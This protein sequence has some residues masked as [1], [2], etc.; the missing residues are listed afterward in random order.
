MLPSNYWGR[1]VRH[2]RAH[3]RCLIGERGN[4][5]VIRLHDVRHSYATA[6]LAAGVPVKVLSA[7]LGHADIATTLRIY[8]H[9]L[10]GDDEAAADATAAAVLGKV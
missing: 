5:P 4:L 6:S 1:G 9:V 2:R 8:A 3:S 10:P 7:R